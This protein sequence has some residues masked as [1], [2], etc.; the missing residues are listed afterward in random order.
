MS[1]TS[2][3]TPHVTG[4]V[5]LYLQ[6]SPDATPAEVESFIIS[7]ATQNI[8]TNSN[9]QNNHL[10]YSVF[11]TGAGGENAVPSADFTFSTDYLNVQ[12]TD[13][14]T[15]SDGSISSWAW[16]FGDGTNSSTQNPSHTYSNAGT[17][18]VSLT[19][20]DD[21]G[22]SDTVSKNVTVEEEAVNVAPD[23]NF[24]FSTDDLSVQFTDQSSDADGSIVNWS[25]NFGNGSSS[26]SQNPS[27]TY[28]QAGSYTVTLTATDNNGES[29]SVSKTVSATEPP[30]AGI[31]LS[32]NG[33]KKKGRWTTDLTWS[34][35]SSSKVDIFR[36]GSKIK[37]VNNS[38]S[39][40]DG[41]NNR[42]SGSLTYKV[43]E[44][45]TSTCSDNVTV[46]F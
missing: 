10:L 21:S 15:D 6:N 18:T 30:V 44:A 14:S 11:D 24:S 38:G 43:C 8:V 32:A 19:V 29:D 3:A 20:T 23:A 36:N 25:W 2:M 12:F 42:G 13:G 31:D 41:T 4:T 9:S 34:G 27:H 1:G 28:S 7:N 39:Y 5:A 17:Y 26:S 37:T 40:T 35:A 33:Y 46:N 16:T 45:G 22:D